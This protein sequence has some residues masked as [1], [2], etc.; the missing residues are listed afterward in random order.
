MRKFHTRKSEKQL[1]KLK[2]CEY[3]GNCFLF[4]GEFDTDGTPA[5]PRKASAYSEFCR[6]HRSVISAEIEADFCLSLTQSPKSARKSVFA[7]TSRRLSSAWTL[8]K[9][10]TAQKKARS[11]VHAII[12]EAGEELHCDSPL[13]LT[14]E[15]HDVD[16]MANLTRA[17]GAMN[18]G[19]AFKGV[20]NNAAVIVPVAAAAVGTP[21][22]SPA[23]R[24][25]NS[26]MS[27][28]PERR[29]ETNSWMLGSDSDDSGAEERGDDE[30]SRLA[31]DAA[32][33][34]AVATVDTVDESEVQWLSTSKVVM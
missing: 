20:S 33:S 11:D 18:L 13:D 27:P 25:T 8:E 26:W 28:A 32:A 7:E 30:P 21:K 4:L 15:G 16:A 10:R 1:L 9:S 34:V 23:R 31:S 19:E 24:T 12:S 3:C 29:R 22:R 6:K 2:P 17:A 5:K 14:G